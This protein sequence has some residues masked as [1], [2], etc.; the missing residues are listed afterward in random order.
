MTTRTLEVVQ[1]TIPDD[2]ELYFN[3][4]EGFELIPTDTIIDK[5]Y[6]GLGATYGEITASRNSIIVLPHVSIVKNK[7]QQHK[8]KNNTFPIYG[9]LKGSSS[10]DIFYYALSDVK[11]KKFLTTPKGLEKIKTAF[12]QMDQ[13]G[14]LHELYSDY[15]LLWDEAHKLV[16]DTGY[17]EDMILPMDDFFKFKN[18][19]M[20]SATPLHF[21]DPR[22][23]EQGFKVVKFKRE[24][25]VPVDIKLV[26]SNS[27]INSFKDYISTN[28]EDTF[29]IFFNS[30][31]GIKSIIN[32]LGIKADSK[33][34]CSQESKSLLKGEQQGYDV[35]DV[36]LE[37]DGENLAK[38]NFFT[39]SFYTGLDINLNFKPIIIILTDCTDAPFSMVDP[40][41]DVPQIIGR[42]RDKIIDKQRI[43]MFKEVIHVDNYTHFTNPYSDEKL[44]KVINCSK[45]AYE[46][47]D[48]LGKLDEDA[49]SRAIFKDIN[50]RIY[51]YAK[52]IDELGRYSPFKEDNF[53][54]ENRINTYYSYPGRLSEAYWQHD[55]FSTTI[56]RDAFEKAEIVRLTG[57]IGKYSRENN[58]LISEI[59]YELEDIKGTPDYIYW[60]DEINKRFQVIHRAFEKLGYNQL[61]ELQFKI[62]DI[63]KLLIKHDYLDMENYHP[64]IDLIY[65]HFHVNKSYTR[66]YI[67]KKLQEFY[68]FLEF[69]AI[70]KASDIQKYFFTKNHNPGK[71][72]K[73]CNSLRL[74]QPK[75]GRHPKYLR[76]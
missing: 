65:D 74:L 36:F 6:P 70:A 25:E 30:I 49:E 10:K 32:E 28:Q 18:K 12:S 37:T 16:K 50:L 71:D 67:K 31:N 17:R 42:V 13:E 8:E 4:I 23:H 61:I 35:S 15:F 46:A 45:A 3:E 53:R 9:E 62:K 1:I 14:R 34:F 19:A 51:P 24:D 54:N 43:R 56:D 38:Y 27:L 47:I 39:S 64:L 66:A 11:Y 44:D 73:S 40:F 63:K 60:H 41:T 29:C 20:V 5:R 68:E 21:R 72:G 52:F 59:L 58:Q 26:H 7:H 69:S 55:Y 76:Q 22:F 75:F 33:I 48:A 2:P 57:S